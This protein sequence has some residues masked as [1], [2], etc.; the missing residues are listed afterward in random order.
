[1]IIGQKTLPAKQKGRQHSDAAFMRAFI[2]AA[3]GSGPSPQQSAPVN[4]QKANQEGGRNSPVKQSGVGDGKGGFPFLAVGGLIGGLLSKPK[5]SSG[6]KAPDIPPQV[7][8]LTGQFQGQYGDLLGQALGGQLGLPDPFYSQQV[9]QGLGALSQQGAN[10]QDMLTQSLAQRGLLRG[11]AQERGMLGIRQAQL[12]GQSNLLTQLAMQD[13]EM[14]RQG[15]MFGLGQYQN[16]LSLGSGQALG[17][18][19][20]DTQRQAF[21]AQQQQQWLNTI[22]GLAGA[23]AQYKYGQPAGG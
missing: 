5:S 18:Q 2:E 23:Y 10:Q 16:L 14:R 19:Q 7:G 1:M 3:T 8:Q 15:Q 6:P 13:L 12:G 22:G 21:D 4:Q 20:I 11:G 17:A 9:T